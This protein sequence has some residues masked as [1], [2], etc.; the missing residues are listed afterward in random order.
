MLSGRTALHKTLTAALALVG[1][2]TLGFAA[3]LTLAINSAL[4]K[5]CRLPRLDSFDFEIVNNQL[6]VPG[7]D[8]W[9]LRAGAAGHRRHIDGTT[10]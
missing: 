1:I 8:R 7:H 3:N 5:D 2:A 10:R 6:L 9:T 4:A